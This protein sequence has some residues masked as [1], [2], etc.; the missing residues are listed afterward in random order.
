MSIMKKLFYISILSLL[1]FTS[2]V[3]LD[4][5]PLSEASSGNWNSTLKEVEMSVNDLYKLAFWGS[6][7]NELGTDDQV[8][9]DNLTFNKIVNATITGETNDEPKVVDTWF[10]A[11]KAIG[12]ANYI[13]STISRAENNL[14][15]DLMKRFIAEVKFARANQYAK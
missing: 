1:I 6:P 15:Q 10:T 7:T 4:L 11:Y 12:R 9:R 8:Y 3:K 2:C 5:N 14:P 13:L